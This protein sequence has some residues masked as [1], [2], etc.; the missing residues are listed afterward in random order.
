MVQISELL[1]ITQR[2]GA[3]DLHLSTK[4]PPI[5]RVNGELAVLD[6]YPV[7]TSDSIKQMVY[8]VMTEAQRTTYERD[9]EIDLAISFTDELRFRVNVFNTI[10]GP[11]AVFR[12]ISS[13]I[14]TLDQINAPPLLKELTMKHK[15]MVLLTGPTGSGKSTTLAAMIDYINET[16]RKHVITIEDPVEFLH[17]SKKSLINQ[18]EVGVNTKTF[19]AALKS[20]LREDPNVILVG[21]LRDLETIQLAVTAAETGHL[22]MGTLHT[23]GAAKT[24]DRLI[25]VFPANEKE[26]IRSMLSG[27]IEAIITQTLLKTKDGQGRIP[28]HEILLGIPSVRNLIREGK[29]AQ[30]NS[31]IQINSKIGMTTL[32]DSIYRLVEQDLIDRETAKMAILERVGEDKDDGP[33]SAGNGNPRNSNGNSS[34][35][36]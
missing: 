9:Y 36:F 28:A 7:L 26:M 19:A 15:G 27:S 31:V 16:Q 1:T 25:D 21:E 5:L 35:G 8:A 33:F 17:I 18:R 20:A 10:D 13:K 22:V 29:I 2:N 3:S 30:I 23:S 34:G 14:M 4:K 12:H 24:I 32:K 11:A 6:N